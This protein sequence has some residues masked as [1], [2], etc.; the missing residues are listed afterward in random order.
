MGLDVGQQKVRKEEPSARSGRNELDERESSSSW[1]Q[2]S[3]T[4]LLFFVRGTRRCKTSPLLHAL[5]SEGRWKS[6]H[7]SAS[8]K[9]RR[10]RAQHLWPRS[11][12]PPSLQICWWIFNAGERPFD[13]YLS[14]EQRTKSVELDLCFSFTFVSDADLPSFL[15]LSPSSHR[16]RL[17]SVLQASAQGSCRSIPRRILS[18]RSP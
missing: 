11:L 18:S 13:R 15:L 1:V 2:S 8:R 6:F 7:S 12:L 17:A 3:R 14:S 9:G 5:G 4:S 16:A 10:A